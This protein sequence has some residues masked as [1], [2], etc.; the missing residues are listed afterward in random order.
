MFE[1]TLRHYG[2]MNFASNKRW[3]T[4]TGLSVGWRKSEEDFIK[5][6][7]NNNISIFSFDDEAEFIEEMN[8]A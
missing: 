4:F 7:G 5:Y 2:S 8:N 1:F 3:G 6:L